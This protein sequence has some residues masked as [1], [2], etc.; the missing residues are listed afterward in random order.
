MRE[1]IYTEQT[2]EL[3]ARIKQA[4]ENIKLMNK[5][6]YEYVMGISITV[7]KCL[8]PNCNVDDLK[9]NLKSIKYKAHYLKGLVQ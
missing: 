1:I 6:V 7:D 9:Q 5:Y 4:E 3:H 8:E 2:A